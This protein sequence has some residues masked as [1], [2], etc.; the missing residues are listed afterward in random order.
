MSDN[1]NNLDRQKLIKQ[2]IEGYEKEL[3]DDE[4]QKDNSFVFLEK[5]TLHMFITF[6]L[7]LLDKQH[8]SDERSDEVESSALQ[9]LSSDL[10]LIMEG[11]QKAF[12][13]LIH[14]LKN[15]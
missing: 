7:M 2:L 12:E 1:Q 11:N 8:N 6:M 9:E 4:G 13:E 15:T 14:I 10:E 3:Q 5:N